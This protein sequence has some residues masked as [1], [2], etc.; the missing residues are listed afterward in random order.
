ME[1]GAWETSER[2]GTRDELK[3]VDRK[4]TNFADAFGDG[5]GS[6]ALL[7]ALKEVNAR[8]ATL[9]AEPAMAKAPVPHPLP[10]LVGWLFGTV[11]AMSVGCGGAQP[12]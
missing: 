3:R 6:A 9:E 11:V 2:D 4:I 10:N 8:K 7:T 5:N 1:Q 12:T